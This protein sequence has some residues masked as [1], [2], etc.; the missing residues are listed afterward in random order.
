MAIHKNFDEMLDMLYKVPGKSRKLY[1]TDVN[2][3]IEF[4]KVLP[5]Q[6]NI[7]DRIGNTV[8]WSTTPDIYDIIECD[9]MPQIYTGDYCCIPDRKSY[10]YIF[11][12]RSK[13]V[14]STHDINNAIY[15]RRSFASDAMIVSVSTPF[16]Q[17]H[18]WYN[19][20]IE[21]IET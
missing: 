2:T 5:Y 15:F 4:D 18:G 21:S 6:I 19:Y 12:I 9:K 7:L 17:P 20:L 16:D 1:T 10:G 8:S 14:L 3:I 13:S 11:H